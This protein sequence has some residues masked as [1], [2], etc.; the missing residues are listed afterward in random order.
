ML[1]QSPWGATKPKAFP[2]PTSRTNSQRPLPPPRGGEGGRLTP[3]LFRA[4]M[5]PSLR[6]IFFGGSLFKLPASPHPGPRVPQG[7]Y[8]P[9]P[10]PPP[11]PTHLSNQKV[12]GEWSGSPAGSVACPPRRR[13]PRPPAASLSSLRRS[14]GL[15]AI[16]LAG[17]WGGGR[18]GRR[19]GDKGR[20]GMRRREAVRG[21]REAGR[22]GGGVREARRRA[23]PGSTRGL[24]KRAEA[25]HRQPPP[26]RCPSLPPEGEAPR[27]AAAVRR[28]GG[29]GGPFPART[30]TSPQSLWGRL[31]EENNLRAQFGLAM[32]TGKLN[33]SGK[34][35]NF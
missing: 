1:P 30:R 26:G 25:Q 21:E 6:R 18:A 31:C 15:S 12:Q 22:T 7:C 34:K 20:W 4:E 27:S 3:G 24:Q 13:R 29:H 35:S 16:S 9:P 23:R 14:G 33:L 28:L 8:P 2:K 17:A 5:L 11:G 19:G 10:P 32:L